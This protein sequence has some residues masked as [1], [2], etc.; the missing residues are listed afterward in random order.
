MC[1]PA[2]SVCK[3]VELMA[4]KDSGIKKVK[5]LSEK[6]CNEQGYELFE[7]SLDKEPTGKYLRIYI[8]TDKPEGITL[9]D[10]ER[11]HRAIQ[12]S[13]E[14]YDYDFLEV[15]SPG[16]DRPVRDEK[17]AERYAGSYVDIKLYKPLN[18]RKEMCVILKAMDKDNIQVQTETEDLSIPRRSVSVIRL[19]PDLSA[20]ED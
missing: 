10:C 15:S 6:L 4:V 12:P 13:I 14:D 3:E 8:D 20:L 17:D 19:H 16:A 1:L 5:S 18:G 11:F 9:D 7:V 2:L